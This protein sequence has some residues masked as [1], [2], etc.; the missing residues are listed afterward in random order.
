MTNKQKLEQAFIENPSPLTFKRLL[1]HDQGEMIEVLKKTPDVN[2]IR[3]AQGQLERIDEYLSLLM[4]AT[5]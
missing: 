4:K 3:F 1:E 5:S 2:N